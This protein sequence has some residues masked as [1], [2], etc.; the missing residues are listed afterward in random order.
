MTHEL[1]YTKQNLMNKQLY[2]VCVLAGLGIFVYLYM[3]NFDNMSETEL[4]NN[5]LYWYTPLIFGLFGLMALRL[6]KTI[7][8]D[9]SAI[10][11]L[12]SGKDQTLTIWTIVLLV[13]TSLVGVLL[14]LIPLNLFKP[15]KSSYDVSVA[16]VGTV[17]WLLALWFFFV[18]IWPS[19]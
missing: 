16:L 13:A 1:T 4:V 19:L 17:I 3:F 18:G 5:V 12:F 9:S 14:L 15:Q 10:N 7:D 8:P 6:K 11:H 2:V